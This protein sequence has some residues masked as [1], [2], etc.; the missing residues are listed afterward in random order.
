MTKQLHLLT[1]TQLRQWVKQAEP[2]AKSDGDGLTFTLS[3]AGT[4][5]WTLRYRQNAQRKEITL[6]NYPDIK[7][8]DAR[9]LASAHRAAVDGGADPAKEKAASKEKAAAVEWTI[10]RLAEDYRTKRL[11]PGSFAD[12]TLYYRNGDLTRVIIPKLGK[13]AVASVTGQDIVQMLVDADDTWTVSKRVLT[14]ASKLFDHAA[15]LRLIA[16]NPCAGVSLVSLFGP[17]PPIKKRVMLSADEL[18]TLLAS[19]DTL[20]TAN[21]LA[22]RILLATC[23]RTSELVSAQWKDID[24]ERGSWFVPDATTK[25]RAGFRVPLTPPVV[26]WFRQLLA[27]SGSSAYV[28]PARISRGRDMPVVTRTLWAAI[29]RA[30]DTGRLTVSKFTPHD[31]RS[32]AKGHMRNL[33]ISEFDTERALSH[34]IK[35]VSGIYDVREEIPEKRRALQ[36]WAD[37]LLTLS[38][39]PIAAAAIRQGE[40]VSIG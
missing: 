26:A 29:T 19:L 12:A 4:A 15:G 5:S 18:R 20:G 27:L 28:L 22:F 8:S 33:G 9:R 40:T 6:G 24:L 38:T 13:R 21:A 25:T 2:I 34:A 1:D 30:F 32:T 7:L 14:T 23:V 17:R 36:V 10:Q 11:V 3:K 31:T 37:F 16:I 35:G 39:L